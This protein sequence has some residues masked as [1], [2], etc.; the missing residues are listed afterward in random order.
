MFSS[1]NLIVTFIKFCAYFYT[2]SASML[3]ESIHSLADAANQV[4]HSFIGSSA[5]KIGIKNRS[6]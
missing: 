5:V 2:G 4:T 6:K 3:S 1:S